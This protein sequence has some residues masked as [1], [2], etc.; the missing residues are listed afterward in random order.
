M[1]VA[2][3]HG[4]RLRT[5][6]MRRLKIHTGCHSHSL[7]DSEDGQPKV[8]HSPQQKIGKQV[9]RPEQRDSVTQTEDNL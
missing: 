4:H 3:G 9:V 8:S 5:G 2:Q 7:D 1:G 6:A